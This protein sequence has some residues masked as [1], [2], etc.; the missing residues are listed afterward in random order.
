MKTCLFAIT[1]MTELYMYL[2]G[3]GVDYLCNVKP[4]TKNG[5][6]LVFIPCNDLIFYKLSFEFKELGYLLCCKF[7]LPLIKYKF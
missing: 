7:I 2:D 4:H 5:N 3:G 6:S 1:N